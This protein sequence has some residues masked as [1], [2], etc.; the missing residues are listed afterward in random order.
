MT[1]NLKIIVIYVQTINSPLAPFNGN[2][3]AKWKKS[4]PHLAKVI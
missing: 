1:G 2:W 4:G 3:Y